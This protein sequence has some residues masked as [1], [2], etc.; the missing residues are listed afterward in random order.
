[1]D[2]KIIKGSLSQIAK[3]QNKSIAE[4]FMHADC[5]VMVDTSGS[6][7][8]QDSRG[9]KTR[10]EVAC[11]ELASVQGRLPG[12]IAVISF[13][14]KVQFCPS[15]L[16]EYFGGGTA[17]DKCLAFARVADLPG[18]HFI[19]ISDGEPNNEVDALREARKFKQKIDT[20]YVGP[21]KDNSGGRAFLHKLALSSGG[22]AVDDF[23]VKALEANVLKLLA[24]D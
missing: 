21:E 9:G 23:Q 14:E 2:N 5:V 17:L 3:D 19:L 15:G 22:Q 10:Y 11:S 12:K 7:S 18:M 1:M 4:T 6:M 13:S 24:A 16:P 8:S 20:I